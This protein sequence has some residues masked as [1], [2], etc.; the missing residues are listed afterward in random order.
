MPEERADRDS[1][2]GDKARA[3]WLTDDSGAAGAGRSVSDP[4]E[5]QDQRLQAGVSP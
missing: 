4:G 1:V 3:G 5:K 2:Q